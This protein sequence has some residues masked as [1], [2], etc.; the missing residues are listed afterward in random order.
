MGR[1]LKGGPF[2]FHAKYVSRLPPVAVAVTIAVI[3]IPATP[4]VVA[5]VVPEAVVKAEA[6]AVSVTTLTL[7]ARFAKLVTIMI[8]LP[9]VVSVAVDI[10]LELIFPFID[11][12]AA[13]IEMIRTSGV[14]A[15]KEQKTAR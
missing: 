14:G 3:V 11:V 5:I 6:P 2:S 10:T 9:A 4:I 1:L 12:S 13:A 15:A 7:L 8:G